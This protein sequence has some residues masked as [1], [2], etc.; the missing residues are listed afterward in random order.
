MYG[1]FLGMIIFYIGRSTLIP[2]LVELEQQALSAQQEVDKGAFFVTLFFR[3]LK[4]SL[5]ILLLST[6][7][8]GILYGYVFAGGTGIGFGM[9]IAFFVLK[10]GGVGCLMALCAM[11]PIV[12]CFGIAYMIL[13]R[14][15]E[16]IY[17]GRFCKKEIRK[18]KNYSFFAD[19]FHKFI[20]ILIV[21]L[22]FLIGC[23]LEVY[24]VPTILQAFS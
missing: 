18:E 17:E 2:S 10:Y 22:L 12:L 8:L 1:S 5:W 14:M 3:N 15:G 4:Q 24:Y 20:Q 11:V 16:E 7:Y 21:L 23:F 13:F 9:L 6:T 19:S